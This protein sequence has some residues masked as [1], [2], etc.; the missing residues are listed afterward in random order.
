MKSLLR[1]SNH[2]THCYQQPPGCV[3]LPGKG[4]VG[5]HLALSGGW[6]GNSSRN[7]GSGELVF[8]GFALSPADIV[9][10]QFC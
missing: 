5:N 7:A 1:R 6:P 9:L 2:I 10:Q 8:P 3:K 4:G